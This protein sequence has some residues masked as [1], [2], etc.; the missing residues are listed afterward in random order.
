[1]HMH[2]NDDSSSDIDAIKVHTERD[3]TS[4]TFSLSVCVCVSSLSALWFSTTP[5]SFHLQRV[6]FRGEKRFRILP[7]KVR[8]CEREFASQ[9][10]KGLGEISKGIFERHQVLFLDPA[11]LSDDG[12]CEFRVPARDWDINLS[13][14]RCRELDI[15]FLE[16]VHQHADRILHRGD[17]GGGLHSHGGLTLPATGP[18]IVGSVR[19]CRSSTQRGAFINTYISIRTIRQR[20]I[21][22]RRCARNG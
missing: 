12:I 10:L 8:L 5:A 4:L 19:M 15:A 2:I 9:L 22:R 7:W 16:V 11:Q 14:C 20:D 1:M 21:D 3:S 13:T 6:E 17:T 18:V